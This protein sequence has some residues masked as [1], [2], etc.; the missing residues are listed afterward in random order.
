[1]NTE[2]KPVLNLL[3]K[4]SIKI[5]AATV[6]AVVII[7]GVLY[8]ND[9]VHVRWLSTNVCKSDNQDISCYTENHGN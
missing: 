5:V 7:L 6:I 4:E 2:L 1:M 8:I 9:R 3:V